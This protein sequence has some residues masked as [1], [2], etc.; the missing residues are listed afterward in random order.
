MEDEDDFNGDVD[1]ELA[2]AMAA[3]IPNWRKPIS[4]DEWDRLVAQRRRAAVS[5]TDTLRG[6]RDS[7]MPLFFLQRCAKQRYKAVQQYRRTSAR[8][9]I[10]KWRMY[11]NLIKVLD[12]ME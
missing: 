4:P 6:S 7:K 2:K 11:Q 3:Y 10:E 12:Q 1:S 8:A 5:T 9:T